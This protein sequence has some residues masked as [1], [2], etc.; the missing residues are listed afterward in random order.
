MG[1]EVLCGEANGPWYNI[2]FMHGHGQF[3]NSLYKEIM[4][5]CP[6]ASLRNGDLSEVCTALIA[7]MNKEIGGYYGYNLYDACPHDGP[8]LRD[9]TRPRQTWGMP[10][11]SASA[12][13]GGAL[14]DYACPG[15]VLNVWLNRS[16]VRAALSIPQNA[17]F[18]SGDNGVG[19]NCMH[20]LI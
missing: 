9:A 15:D 7:R 1:N 3:S 2:E 19:F 13:V 6:E 5:K 20:F 16:D 8:F 17:N 12:S 10:S 4:S 11:L 14:N 18:F